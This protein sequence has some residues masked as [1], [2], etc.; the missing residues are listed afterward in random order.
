MTKRQLYTN[1]A[2]I[3]FCHE[4]HENTPTIVVSVIGTQQQK[5]EVMAETK[6]F[7]SQYL[8][9]ILRLQ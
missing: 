8:I 7:S 1:K 2:C 3:G 6:L 5:N 4:N 9:N